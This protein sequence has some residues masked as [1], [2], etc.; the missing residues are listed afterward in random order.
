MQRLLA[1]ILFCA[2]IFCL[3]AAPPVGQSHAQVPMTGAGK[4]A[5]GGGAGLGCAGAAPN[6]VTSAWVLAAVTA[7]GGVSGTVEAAVDCFVVSSKTSAGGTG[8]FD[9]LDRFFVLAANDGANKA[10]VIDLVTSRK[11]RHDTRYRNIQFEWMDR[12][13]LY[14][15]SRHRLDT[16]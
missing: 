12:Q 8:E 2:G 16:F 6:A 15:L 9:L 3:A 10:Q 1:I 11:R 13:R 5:P 14:R 4:G 7:G